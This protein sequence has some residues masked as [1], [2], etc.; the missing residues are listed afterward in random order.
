MI[1]EIK[2]MGHVLTDEQQVQV[3]ICP[4]PHSWEH[5][6]IHLTYNE[7]IQIMDNILHHLKLGKERLKSTK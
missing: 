7:N 2:D 3:V 5:M 1:Y 6:R 4:M